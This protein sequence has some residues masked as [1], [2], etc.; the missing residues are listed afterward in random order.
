MRVAVD[1]DGVLADIITTWILVYDLPFT[2][3][4][5]TEYDFGNLKQYGVTLDGFLQAHSTLWGMG[6]VRAETKDLAEKVPQI[7]FDIVTARPL[8]G[9]KDVEIWLMKHRIKYGKILCVDSAIEKPILN[10][11]VYIDDNPFMHE[12]LR[13]GQIQIMVTQPWNILLA[14]PQIKRAVNIEHA[15]FIL[16]GLMENDRRNNF[17]SVT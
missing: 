17:R 7:D 1:V 2:K 10:Y 12:A 3:K 5:V 16:K 6:V 4:Q 13:E 11:D 14:H 9:C 15:T 8:G